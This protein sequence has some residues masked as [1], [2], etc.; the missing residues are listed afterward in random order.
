MLREV[1]M[2]D[3]EDAELVSPQKCIKNTLQIEQF[4][5]SPCWTFV[6]DIGHLE[7]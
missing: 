2:V 6:E 1:K 5:Q 3:Q 7:G 4:S